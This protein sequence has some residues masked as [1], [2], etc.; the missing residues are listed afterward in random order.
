[1]PLRTIICE[2]CGTPKRT[3][4]ARTRFC[5]NAH[6]MVNVP[7]RPWPERRDQPANRDKNHRRRA[8][9]RGSRPARVD[10]FAV[11]ERDS[12]TCHLCEHFV[13]RQLAYPDPASASL[14]H[15]VPLARGGRHETANVAL[16]HLRCN[17][18]RG[19][20]PLAA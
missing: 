1:M 19:A 3:F 18:S 11:Y 7:H 13:D 4:Y 14:D 5:S 8:V 16:A 2:T 6:R 9:I 10:P 20:K 15:L 17:Q 12:W